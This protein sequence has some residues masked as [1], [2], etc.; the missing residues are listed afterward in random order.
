MSQLQQQQVWAGRGLVAVAGEDVDSCGHAGSLVQGSQ[1][2]AFVLRACSYTHDHVEALPACDQSL[3]SSAVC[4][5][6][7]RHAAHIL[8]YPIH[9]STAQH[10]EVLSKRQARMQTTSASIGMP[11]TA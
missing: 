9:G 7:G 8:A 4:I 1:G 11:P 5:C 6:H 10:T 3:L 2:G